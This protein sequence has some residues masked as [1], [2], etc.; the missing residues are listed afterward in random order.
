MRRLLPLA[1]LA[2][3]CSRNLDV[4]NVRAVAVSPAV[5]T[6][7]PRERLTLVGSGG[8]GGYRF[9]FE[10]DERPSGDDAAL[11]AA[12]GL[13][14]AGSRGSAQDVVVVTD[15]AGARAVARIAVGPRLV[16]TPSAAVTSPGGTIEVVASGGKPPYAFALVDA[17]VATS[18][19]PSGEGAASYAAGPLGDRTERIVVTDV[20]WEAAD[21]SAASAACEVRV[22][23]AVK[24]YANVASQVAPYETIDFLAVGGQP[25]YTFDFARRDPATGLPP[26]GGSID[27]ATGRYRAGPTGTA[28]DAA[29]GQE[30]ADEIVARDAY[31]QTSAPWRIVVGPPLALSLADAYL[32][33]ARP[34]RLTASGGKPPYAFAFALRGNRSGGTV[35]GVTGVYV[36]GAGQGSWDALQVTDATGRAQATIARAPTVGWTEIPVGDRAGLVL[37][38]RL[39]GDQRLDTNT[40][41]QDALVFHYGDGDTVAQL[42]SVFFPASSPISVSHGYAN[43]LQDL[44]FVLDV[45]ADGHDDLVAFTCQPW[46]GAVTTYL[47]S[48][49]GD[50]VPGPS[51]ALSASNW[52]FLVAKSFSEPNRFYT[53]IGCNAGTGTNTGVTAV[54]ALPGGFVTSCL[55]HPDAAALDA[56]RMPIAAA[57]LDGNGEV[58]LAWIESSTTLR[59][60]Y[61]TGGAFGP[62][63]AVGAPPRC[64]LNTSWFHR[65]LGAL[66]PFSPAGSTTASLAV[67]FM[68]GLETRIG[69][70]DGGTGGSPSPAFVPASGVTVGAGY[71]YMGTYRAAP[72][73][74][75]SVAGWSSSFNLIRGARFDPAGAATT[76]TLAPT[77]PMNI[78]WAAFPDVDGDATPD[79]LAVG[80]SLDAYLLLG[81]G[82]G[83]FGLRPRVRGVAAWAPAGD[84]DGDGLDDAVVATNDRTLAILLGG[85]DQL[86]W[87]PGIPLSGPVASLTVADFMGTGTPSITFQDRLGTV[88]RVTIGPGLTLGTPTPV[89]FPWLLTARNGHRLAELG[90]AAPGPD[91]WYLLG[92]PGGRSYVEAFVFDTTTTAHQAS[93]PIPD[94]YYGCAQLPVGIGS[95]RVAAVCP[96]VARNG[97]VILTTGDGSFAQF[98]GWT[99]PAAGTQANAT[100]VA[101]GRDASGAGVFVAT[102]SGPAGT[103]HRYAVTV[104]ASPLG[105]RVQDLGAESDLP[106]GRALL[107]DVDGDGIPD[108]VVTENGK[109]RVLL[110]AAT[111]GGGTTYTYTPG[112]TFLGAGVASAGMHLGSPGRDLVV[113]LGDDLVIVPHTGAGQLR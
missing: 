50:L 58:D 101:A 9:V 113:Q 2:A 95:F 84:L 66:L 40:P 72:G 4:P 29:A 15:S 14:R 52:W 56:T 79:L 28:P 23:S 106:A 24:V 90:G 45:D 96:D 99:P 61:R 55:A 38:A 64:S 86:A 7:A 6:V 80:A 63:V 73:A 65:S 104:T 92:D 13:Y 70:L 11:D 48:V 102:P 111:P 54:D 21:P 87:Q 39:R 25:G 97:I 94:P 17:Q 62:G 67:P 51:L 59:V 109:G 34:V 78:T 47:A 88:Y 35:D 107:T 8:A 53:T 36:P 16:V 20:T 3:A 37:A 22:G 31:G 105:A 110:G 81:D 82:D 77:L 103:R 10:G 74:D 27:P 60:S 1:V 91:V 33:P 100:V 41:R 42:S 75:V 93:A 30:V 57:D 46:P 83:R 85:A 19:V 5:A 69:R 68:C 44:P 32:S 76:L 18:L 12:T 98:T 89:A 43:G 49:T 26:S 112:P 108:V 71:G